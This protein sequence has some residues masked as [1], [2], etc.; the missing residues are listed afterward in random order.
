MRLGRRWLELSTSVGTAGIGKAA[1]VSSARTRFNT[2]RHEISDYL[3]ANYET[4]EVTPRSW[5]APT[6]ALA[7]RTLGSD[8][9][10]Q[11]AL[12][13]GSNLNDQAPLPRLV[14]NFEERGI[15]EKDLFLVAYGDMLFDSPQIFGSPARELGIS[16]SVCH[17][18]GD[19]NRA[20]FIPGI[21]SRPGGADVDGHFFNPRFNDRRAECPR[22]AVA[23]RHPFHRSLRPRRALR[24]PAQLRAQRHRQ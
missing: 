8:F 13:P 12:P 16:C 6:P 3:I 2:A 23:A 5:Y 10:P 4:G 20:F 18:R 9:R 14:L 19:I 21:S 24:E 11:P 1:R 7:L 22:H 15:D 17:N